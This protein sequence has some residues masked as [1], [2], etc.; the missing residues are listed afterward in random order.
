MGNK[1][2]KSG[3]AAL[4]GR[5]NVGK[6]TLLNYF[7]KEN[8]S[9]TSEKPQTTRDSILGIITDDN[10]QVIFVDTPGVHKPR[11]KLGECM[12]NSAL[13]SAEDADEIIILIDASLGITSEDREIFRLLKSKGILNNCVWSCVLFNKVDLIAHQKLLPIMDICR[14][15][16][17]VNEYIP[18]SAV[19]GENC[20]LVLS[21]IKEGL[22][23]GPAYYPLAQL[24][25]RSERF[26]AGEIIREQALLFCRQEIPHA[27]AVEI[28]DFKDAPA[29]KILIRANI[30]VERQTQKIILIGKKGNML[31]QIGSAARKKIEE[32]LSREVYLELWVKVHADW[33]KDET[34]LARL[35]YR[36]KDE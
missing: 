36:V 9:I 22:P 16:L 2:F 26:F 12:V 1:T 6:S 7:L 14:K 28:E 23:V 8:L 35:G 25:D 32:F 11:T 30:F 13:G 19:T 31:K 17:N 10:Y 15:E 29:G 27:L 33:R 24:T 21:K 20:E 4:L 34:F 5:P 18:V 3:Y